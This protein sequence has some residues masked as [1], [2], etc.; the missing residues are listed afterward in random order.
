MKKNISM[1][2]IAVFV[3]IP[4][5]SFAQGDSVIHMKSDEAITQEMI[6]ESNKEFDEVLYSD[7]Y[8]ADSKSKVVPLT[9]TKGASGSYP[10]RAGVILT[11][12]DNENSTAAF[13]KLGHAA[14]VLDRDF[15]IEAVLKGVRKGKNNWK[16]TK[17]NALGG[18]VKKT[19]NAQDKSVANW[20]KGK[21]GKP[22]NFGFYNITTRSKFY[23]SHL[24]WAGFKDKYGVNLNTPKYSTTG[25]SGKKYNAVAPSELL[26]KTNINNGKVKIVYKQK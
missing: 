5:F 10:K 8:D 2:I 11:T 17:N 6:D 25:A 9:R 7:L 21:I 15:V 1:I 18:E 12:K 26:G 22:Y 24:V 13:F 14:I 20:C 19:S 4:S 3:L 16:T 23:C